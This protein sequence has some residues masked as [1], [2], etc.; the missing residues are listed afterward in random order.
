MSNSG[1][2][3]HALLMLWPSYLAFVISF[4][5]IL[6]IWVKHH[7]MVSLIQKTDHAFLYWNGLLLICITFL[8]FPTG[9]LAEYLLHAEGKV[10]TTLYSGTF[11]A[12][13]LAFKG[14]WW[15]ATTNARLLALHPSIA[16]VAEVRRITEQDRYGPYLYL[17]AFGTSFFSESLS[18][19]ICLAVS[20]LFVFRDWIA[21]G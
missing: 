11:L 20:L 1:G 21:K 7:W 18:I 12:I 10:A 5:S 19:T 16:S 15:H 17:L 4:T 14:L 9:L 8:P 6:M 3:A 13:S 2:L